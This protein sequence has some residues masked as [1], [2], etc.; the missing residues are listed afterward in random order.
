MFMD[1]VKPSGFLLIDKPATWTSHDVVA[2]LRRITGVKKIGH[3]G[4]LDPFATGLLIV[5]VERAA[6]RRLDEFKGMPKT[7]EATVHLGASSDTLDSDGA[8]ELFPNDPQ[9]SRSVVEDVITS[10]LGEQEQTPP[11]F[12]AKKIGGKKL[13]DLAREGKTVERN[14]VNITIHSIELLKYAY[15]E[16]HIRVNA[17]SGTY[18]RVLAAD[19]GESLS[20][21]AY[22]SNLRRTS[23]GNATVDHAVTLNELSREHWAS[24]L[25]KNPA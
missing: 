16:L 10:F 25:T 21:K 13:Y 19:I 3:A 18:I 15:P 24:H 17:S 7:Y 11:M 9:P 2:K 23:I 8:I 5:G 14:P 4:T 12:S 20:T 22:C 6:T 1:A